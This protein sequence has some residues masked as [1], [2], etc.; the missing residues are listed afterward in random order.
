MALSNRGGVLEGTVK[1]CSIICPPKSSP[2]TDVMGQRRT[3]LLQ[4]PKDH[5][6][7]IE[8]RLLPNLAE[9][10]SNQDHQE[11]LLSPFTPTRCRSATWSVPATLI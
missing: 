2:M 6:N 1:R 3:A 10:Q 11:S 9:G 5:K 4:V 8:P 7:Q